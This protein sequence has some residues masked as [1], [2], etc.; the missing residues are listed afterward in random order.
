MTANRAPWTDSQQA[1]QHILEAEE[2]MDEAEREAVGLGA[3]P[4]ETRDNSGPRDVRVYADPAG[5]SF[6]LATREGRDQAALVPGGRPPARNSVHEPLTWTTAEPTFT[7]RSHRHH[8]ST[9][10]SGQALARSSDSKA[11]HWDHL[12]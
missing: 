8:R 1:R 12:T 4:V 9:A 11:G 10:R 6:T 2:D 5:H 7:C 3:R